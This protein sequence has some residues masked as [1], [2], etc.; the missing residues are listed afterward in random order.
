MPDTPPIHPAVAAY[1][2]Q[3]DKVAA[4]VPM[5]RRRG[6][7]E[8]IAA[9]LSELVPLGVGDE[10]AQRALREFGPPAEI[11]AQ[12][13][14][15][16]A[17]PRMRHELIIGS[18]L[19][20]IVLIGAAALAAS[21]F[22]TS[23]EPGFAPTAAAPL[24]IVNSNPEGPERVTEGSAFREYAHAIAALPP[25]PE[26][27]S[28]PSGVPAG[29]DKGVVPDGSGVMEASAGGDVANFTYA[30]AWEFEYLS[31]A[32]NDDE[33]RKDAAYLAL[34]T[35][36]T[37]D[38]GTV[39]DPT[40]AWPLHVLEPLLAGEVSELRLDVPNMCF[41]AGIRVQYYSLVDQGL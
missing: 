24:Q 33:E 31:A 11:V 22:T 8:E 32:A 38:F 41:H 40:G 21:M 3:F 29:L 13:P 14:N 39:S 9:H 12:E 27:A 4:V 30:C 17:R 18:A 34:S 15:V 37:G 2:K 19:A 16:R 26:G 23:S 25:L 5:D 36:S 6:L 10:E 7:R 1:L 35:W 28:W 20:A